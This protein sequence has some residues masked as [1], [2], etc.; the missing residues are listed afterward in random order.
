MGAKATCAAD[1]MDL[2]RPLHYIATGILRALPLRAWRHRRFLRPRRHRL[3]P[4]VEGARPLRVLAL[5]VYL[6][7][8]V[9]SAEHIAA[10]LAKSGPGIEVVQRWAA[11]GTV[12]TN[13]ELARLTVVQSVEMQPKFELINRA[14]VGV[15]IS[16][17]DYVL[18]CDDDIYLPD[19]FVAFFLAYQQAFDLA[20]AQPAR[21]WH[22]HFDHAFALRRPWLLAR[23]TRFVE[24]GPLISIRRDAASFLVPFSNPAQL[25]GLDL[26]WPV[27]IERRGLKMGII[28][29]IAVD[30]S[31]RPQASAYDKEQQDAAMH[32]FLARIEH[33]P[34]KEA[35]IVLDRYWKLPQR[36]A[37]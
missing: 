23:R 13:P 27:E 28:D 26:V 24:C 19:G 20:L 31:L 14:L 35:F 1:T 37:S 33:L 21:A 25:W 5:G 7:E 2:V 22:S 17:F 10:A 34:M 16:T 6:S 29:A 12:S 9:H 8:G 3:R 30:H 36:G 4:P 11:I 32:R 18:V 15:E